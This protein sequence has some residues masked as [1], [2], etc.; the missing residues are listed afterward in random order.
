MTVLWEPTLD[1][2]ATRWVA[3][4]RD[5]N[6]EHFGPLA[7]EIDR[8]QRYPWESVE[9]LVDAG[10][11]GLMIPREYGGE[12]A[13]LATGVAVMA[14]L[15][16]ACASTGAIYAIYALG[17]T[18]IVDFANDEQKSF[19]LPEIRAGRAVSFAL[20]ERGAGSDPAALKA[21]GVAD[22]DGWR[23]SGEKIFIGNG[24]ASQHY[25]AFV[26]T[27]PE[28]GPRGIT[29]FM[30]G[31]DDDGTEVTKYADRMGLRGA[32]TSNLILDTHVPAD[33]MVGDRGRGLRIALSTLNSGRII[34]AAQGL[35]LAT[36]AFEQAATEAVR[37][38]TFGRPIMDNQAISF[39]LAD[40]ATKLSAARMLT[41]EAAHA[42]PDSPQTRTLACMAKLYATEVAGE[43]VDLAVQVY[44]GDGYCKPNPVE[45]LYRD[46]RILEIYEGTSEIQRLTI[47]RAIADAASSHLLEPIQPAETAYGHE[48]FQ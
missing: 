28:A 37:R 41:W 34:I 33:R 45:R 30:T 6:R 38:R 7:A 48:A 24:G 19:Y 46:Q 10:L 13:S 17:A 20:T 4:T 31:L 9:K 23:L 3:T 5:L 16:R 44:G 25:V 47:G 32:R 29:A 43:A 18:P 27:D 15:T 14:E 39:R 8:D 2:E 22:G 11:T 35:G 26:V 1:D 40:V 21:T 42:G 12:G 36:A